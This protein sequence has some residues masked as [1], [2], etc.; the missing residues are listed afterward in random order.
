MW[1]C[2][3]GR[4]EIQS[5]AAGTWG[6]CKETILTREKQSLFKLTITQSVK[7]F[8]SSNYSDG[9][10]KRPKT[11]AIWYRHI[12]SLHINFT[13]FF[14]NFEFYF[15]LLTAP[16]SRISV[17]NQSSVFSI[18]LKLLPSSSSVIISSK[19]FGEE[20][21]LW[22]SLHGFLHAAVSCTHICANALLPVLKLSSW[23]ENR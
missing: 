13:L 10:L 2:Q 1:R 15:I 5:S 9:L 3:A 21:R 6:N 20:C 16:K 22:S 7:M 8:Q 18:I 23:N 4:T 11:S 12:Q 17:T 19:I 14:L